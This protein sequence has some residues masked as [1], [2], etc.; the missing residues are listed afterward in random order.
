MKSV[1]CH[2][3]KGVANSENIILLEN[4]LIKTSEREIAT[5]MNNFFINNTKNLDLESSIKCATKVLNSIVS[6]F[7]DQVLKSSK[8]L[9]QIT[10]SMT[11]TFK[12]SL[13]KMLGTKF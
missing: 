8:H 9:F 7:D 4:N 3:G 11:L 10:T 2:F 13:W 12:L 1:K 5:M 6:K